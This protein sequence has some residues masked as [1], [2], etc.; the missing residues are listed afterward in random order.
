MNWNLYL[1]KTGDKSYR[2]LMPDDKGLFLEIPKDGY[3]VK[4]PLNP[5]FTGRRGIA[6]ILESLEKFSGCTFTF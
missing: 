5:H 4:W 1:A 2:I 3:A 6:A